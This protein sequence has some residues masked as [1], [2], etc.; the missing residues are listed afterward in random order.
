MVWVTAVDRAQSRRRCFGH[1]PTQ[2]QSRARRSDGCR[3]E[4][5]DGREVENLRAVTGGLMC[6][7]VGRWAKDGG[8]QEAGGRRLKW[9]LCLGRGPLLLLAVSDDSTVRGGR[10]RLTWAGWS[11]ETDFTLMEGRL[12]IK[13]GGWGEFGRR[14]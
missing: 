13:C 5:T 3:E 14:K 7:E 1:R 4:G 8:R 6:C 9:M 10:H 12:D 2:R 11:A